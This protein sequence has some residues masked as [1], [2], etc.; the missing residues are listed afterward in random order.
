MRIQ[1]T[2]SKRPFFG[3]SPETLP[4]KE[5]TA[6]TIVDKKVLAKP[7]FAA[8]VAQRSKKVRQMVFTE[9]VLSSLRSPTT[10]REASARVMRPKDIA[11][12]F[13]RY[14][15]RRPKRVGSM[16]KPKRIHPRAYRL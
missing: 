3:R 2:C 9:S 12:N 1:S 10:R 6:L 15:R 11:G 13:S 14:V 5:G 7:C 16:L 8:V 4:A